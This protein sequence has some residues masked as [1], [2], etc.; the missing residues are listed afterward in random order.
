M[1]SPAPDEGRTAAI[2]GSMDTDTLTEQGEDRFSS[3]DFGPMVINESIEPG[4]PSPQAVRLKILLCEDD[5]RLSRALLLHLPRAGP[6]PSAVAHYGR[7]H[8][9]RHAAG[10]PRHW[11]QKAA[12]QRS[13]LSGQG[14]PR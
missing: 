10:A 6:L 12:N 7:V 9:S 13:A 5:P 8:L 2:S 1:A 11:M 14:P 4:D 3:F